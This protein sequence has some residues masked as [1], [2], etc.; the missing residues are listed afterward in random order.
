MQISATWE[1]VRALQD[2]SK[3][4]HES[5][6]SLREASS[7]F[8]AAFQILKEECGPRAERFDELCTSCVIA[9][10]RAAESVEELRPGL[11]EV[12]E[13]LTDFL[14]RKVGIVTAEA[15][16]NEWP[17]A[18]LPNLS[19]RFTG[20]KGNSLFLP[21]DKEARRLLNNHGLH[22]VVY[23][24]GEPDF[25][26]LTLIDTPWGEVDAQVEIAHMT[27][28]RTN[29]AWEFGKRSADASYDPACD[30]GNFNQADLELAMRLVS[31]SP[32][33]L[34]SPGDD[35][36]RHARS[37]LCRQ[38]AAFRKIAD[39]TWH[40]CPDGKTMQL[41]PTKIHAACPHTGGVAIARAV[42]HYADIDEDPCL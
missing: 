15:P 11:Y 17:T 34:P 42:Q 22:G 4:M 3:M 6:M 13:R 5:A 35:D 9:T 8:Q 26:P 24:D 10:E 16:K 14:N 39:L 36:Y 1:S 33:L 18:R 20:K 19:G 27:P 38:I 21:N 40:E 31:S 41:I 37:R 28:D 12:S 29:R 25:S 32:D 23:K 30:M 2:F 7:E